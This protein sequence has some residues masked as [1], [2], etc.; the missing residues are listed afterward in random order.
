MAAM[1]ST[2]NM[3]VSSP[4]SR[5][6]SAD[7]IVYI[8]GEPIDESVNISDS[9]SEIDSDEDDSDGDKFSESSEN[10]DSSESDSEEQ[11]S[12]RPKRSK[13][14]SQWKWS[15]DDGYVSEKIKFSGLF[16]HISHLDC[17]WLKNS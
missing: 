3:G 8:L 2:N 15:K 16:S 13:I 7:I 1:L 10:E 4:W 12:A 6:P 14:D 9:G 5:D 11:R 17:N